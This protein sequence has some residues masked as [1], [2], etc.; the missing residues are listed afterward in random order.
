VVVYTD[1]CCGCHRIIHTSVCVTD[2]PA[3]GLVR[4]QPRELR[5]M[6]IKKSCLYVCVCVLVCVCVCVVYVCGVCV[7]VGCVCVCAC[8]CGCVCVC[9]VREGS[10]SH[11]ISRTGEFFTPTCHDIVT[12]S[13]LF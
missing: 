2:E 10:G 13:V 4:L 1:A 6:G 5:G 7:C 8:V 9:V 11:F 12:F 3:T